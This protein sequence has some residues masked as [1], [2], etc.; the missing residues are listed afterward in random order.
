MLRHIFS[1]IWNYLPVY[2]AKQETSSLILIAILNLL[3][4]SEI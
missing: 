1:F 3:C 2:F 4:R